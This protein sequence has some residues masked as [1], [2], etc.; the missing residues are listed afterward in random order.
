MP[1]TKAGTLKPEIDK[2]R[3]SLRES[4][5]EPRVATRPGRTRLK[6]LQRKARRLQALE[7]HRDA[8]ARPKEA[9]AE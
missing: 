4:G 7:R 2:L 5:E 3:K 6:R 1:K 8:G 9:P